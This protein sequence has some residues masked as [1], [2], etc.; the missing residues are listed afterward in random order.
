VTERLSVRHSLYQLNITIA[1]SVEV[2]PATQTS[3]IS[4]RS[5]GFLVAVAVE[6]AVAAAASSWAW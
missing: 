6:A 2:V 3:P 5:A 4:A 1:G